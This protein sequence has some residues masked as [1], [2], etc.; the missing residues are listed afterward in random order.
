MLFIFSLFTVF[1]ICVRHAECRLALRED[2]N[3]LDI[4]WRMVR[5]Q[6]IQSDGIDYSLKAGLFL[7][8][9]LDVLRNLIVFH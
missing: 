4:L 6:L 3:S 2:A 9:F 5:F 1:G 8:E 7:C